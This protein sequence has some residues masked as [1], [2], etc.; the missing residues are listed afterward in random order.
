M[1]RLG[2]HKQREKPRH[3]A[4]YLPILVASLP[5]SGHFLNIISQLKPTEGLRGKMGVESRRPVP[6][7]EMIW[8]LKQIGRAHV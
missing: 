4:S 2:P 5:W 8:G 1:E 6:S 7:V 3:M